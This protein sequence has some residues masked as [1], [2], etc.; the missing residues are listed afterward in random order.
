MRSYRYLFILLLLFSCS[1]PSVEKAKELTFEYMDLPIDQKL[2][3][4]MDEDYLANL[5]LT[6]KEIDYVQEYYSNRSYSPKWINDSTLTDLGKRTKWLYK[7]SLQIGIPEN[8]MRN[9]AHFNYIQ[10]EI[11]ITV[12]AAYV[13]SD[14]RDG[15][16]D[17][18]TK[19][20]KE[21]A[22][23]PVDTLD[24]MTQFDLATDLRM[25]YIKF[26]PADTT[27]EVLAKGLM[28]FYDRYPVDTNTFAVESI[29]YD[30]S[31]WMAKTHE[32]LHS[33]GYLSDTV[34]E[35][36][37]LGI[38]E[39]LKVFQSHNGLKPDGVVGK[40]T[41]R[42]LNESSKRKLLRIA[43]AMDKNRSERTY[44]EKYI[45]INIPEYR[46]RFYAD[47][48]LRRT[49]N[50]VVGKS[51]TPTP[52]LEAKLSKL[53][54]YP[55]WR[56]PYSI[57][58]K[59]ILPILKWNV[60]HLAKNNYRVYKDTT[61]IDPYIV[62]W[63]S[64]RQNAFPYR[65]I[66]DPGPKNSLG[67]L[68]FDFYNPHSVYFHDTP[69][70]ALFGV[71]V[72]AYSHGC[73]RTQDP[74]DLA[75]EILFYDSISPRKVN[76]MRPDSLDSLLNVGEHYEIKL[77]DRVPIYVDYVTVVREGLDMVVY[78]DVYGRDEEYIKVMTENKPE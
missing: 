53:V 4:A 15:F 40:F 46:L 37:S 36:D 47:D 16:M 12:N 28:W 39:A 8:R 63:K 58:S 33:K 25:Q 43:L 20:Y 7:K 49:H 42:C 67:I 31:G 64:I 54:V 19:K 11:S 62:N 24:L 76:V 1:E 35:T 57:S 66:Q 30:S 69:A 27:Y 77:V 70:K 56:V 23:I 21:A 74:V 26:G 13:L 29:K 10:E 14:L 17:Y 44:P 73:M 52:E 68:K 3:K 61:E 5:G 71:D 55:Y 51:E 50:L 41:S 75:K 72:R 38:V 65:I 48:T 59:E 22:P 34:S 45:R 32:A 60:G 18:E 9:V 2:K 6:E 78:H